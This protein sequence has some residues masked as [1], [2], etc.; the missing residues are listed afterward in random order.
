VT[1]P[2][3]P[4]PVPAALPLRVVSGRRA[5]RGRRL[6]AWLMVTV[7]VLAAFLL[8]IYSR[9]ALDRSAFVMKEIDRQTSIEEA[10]YWELRLQAA[11]LQAPGRILQRALEMGMVYPAETE[12]IEVPGIG[13]PGSGA[14]D[15]WADLKALLGAQP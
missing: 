8:L 5:R 14:E 15:H 1:A 13:S 11:E 9:I 2:A 10:H 12:T 6:G 4:L 7:V 3:H